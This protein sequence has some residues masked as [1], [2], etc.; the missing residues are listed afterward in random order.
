MTFGRCNLTV[1]TKYG[2]TSL[3]ARCRGGS[4]DKA[5]RVLPFRDPVDYDVVS[6]SAD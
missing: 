6:R 3:I 5:S 4:P 1:P 2:I